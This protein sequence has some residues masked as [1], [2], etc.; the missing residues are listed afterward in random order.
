MELSLRC[1]ERERWREQLARTIKPKKEDLKVKANVLKKIRKGEEISTFSNKEIQVLSTI[2]SRAST[3][4][5][6]GKSYNA[7]RDILTVLGYPK[8]ITWEECLSAYRRQDIAKAVI[9]RPI[10]ATWR[11]HFFIQDAGADDSEFEKA[12]HKLYHQLNIKSYFVRLDKLASLGSFACLFMGF[13][14]TKDR[15]ELQKP[16]TAKNEMTVGRTLMF[17]KPLGENL[18]SVKELEGD[19]SNP[20]YGLPRIY[21]V[22]FKDEDDE[23]LNAPINE[24]TKVLV[25][26]SRMLH[27]TG[28]TLQSEWRGEPVLEPIFNR[29][30]DLEKLVGGSAEMFWRGARPGYFGKVDDDF[31]VEESTS[32]SLE[33]QTEEYENNLRRILVGQGVELTP[34]ATQV[35]DPTKHVNVQIQMISAVTGIPQRVLTGSEVGELASTQDRD[36]WSDVIQTRRQEYA[37]AQIIKPFI[38]KC[39]DSGALPQPISDDY[40]VEWPDIYAPSSKDKAD[41][42]RI[43]ADSLSKYLSNPYV[44]N[45]ITF[46]AFLTY[47]CGL[48]EDDIIRIIEMNQKRIFKDE[49]DIEAIL[50]EEVEESSDKSK[51]DKTK[52][53]VEPKESGE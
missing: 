52:E 43:R 32:E 24:V 38:Q 21:E 30:K 19:P 12:W 5:H 25:H 39:V 53:K 23:G 27:V 41:I 6:W 48:S 14:D 8:D 2:V 26:Y 3:A 31:D 40:K 51:K 18:V 10:Q 7:Q 15:S 46:E 42:G 49:I 50:A 13:N 37:E 35:V 16:L 22:E 4:R 28:D 47:F 1:H 44:S 36:N 11:D 34:L 20:R 9:N 33:R 29:L 17:V 45:E